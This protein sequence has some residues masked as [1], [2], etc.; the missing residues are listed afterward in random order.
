MSRIDMRILNMPV[1]LV[2]Y[3]TQ[4]TAQRYTKMSIKILC[5]FEFFLNNDDLGPINP[6]M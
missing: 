4:I 5:F 6:F 2:I 3:G 1:F